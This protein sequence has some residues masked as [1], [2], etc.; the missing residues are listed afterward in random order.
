VRCE[1]ERTRPLAH[2]WSRSSSVGSSSSESKLSWK[3]FFL[4]V[5]CGGN[6]FV[7]AAR[8]YDAESEPT[9]GV[10]STRL[11]GWHRWRG[12]ISTGHTDIMVKVHQCYLRAPCFLEP[13]RQPMVWYSSNL[14]GT[15][16]F[17][18]PL[19]SPGGGAEWQPIVGGQEHT[20]ADPAYSGQGPTTYVALR[21][22]VLVSM[23][24]TCPDGTWPHRLYAAYTD[25]HQEAAS[26][27]FTGLVLRELNGKG[28]ARYC[29][30]VAT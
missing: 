3:V 25:N 24:P 12:Q 18:S 27:P 20:V 6:R 15:E 29:I 28:Y 30:V 1:A 9:N 23:R 17:V 13:F 16:P 21:C 2:W 26:Y 7:V 14:T 19:Q 10:S 5:E 4:W 8:S 22:T 11:C